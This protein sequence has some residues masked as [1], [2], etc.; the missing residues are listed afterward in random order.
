M[1]GMLAIT[2][3]WVGNRDILPH[4]SNHGPSP[5]SSLSD[6][7]SV[8]AGSAAASRCVYNTLIRLAVSHSPL[9][10][11]SVEYILRVLQAKNITFSSYDLA[12]DEDA[13][14]LWR[15]KAP[16]GERYTY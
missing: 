9:I 8:A 3:S 10:T 7:D 11:N 13:K 6:D 14:R 4:A 2:I 1:G 5:H 15:R 12:S 16:P